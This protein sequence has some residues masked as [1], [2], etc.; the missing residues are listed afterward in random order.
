MKFLFIYLIIIFSIFSVEREEE[1]LSNFLDFYFKSW[2]S[3]DMKGYES[4]FHQDAMIQVKSQKSFRTQRLPEFIEEQKL[5]LSMSVDK[6]TE[7]PLAKKIY[8]EKETAHAQVR[9]KLSARGK[10]FTGWDHFTLIKS[11]KGW[12]ILYLY[13]YFDE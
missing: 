10:E 9:W 2:S 13:F 4:C 8:I 7:I 1:K 3:Q 11:E 6:M 5:A 12:K